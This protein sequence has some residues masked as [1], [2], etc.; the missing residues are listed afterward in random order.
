MT[1]PRD[2][3]VE[4]ARSIYSRGLTHGSTGNL[5]VRSGDRIFITPT[6]SSLGTVQ[7]DEIAEIDLDGTAITQCKPSKEAFIHAAILRIRP[8]LRAVVHTH[9]TYAT[10]VSCLP[11]LHPDSTLPPLTV[12]FEMRV[13]SLPLVPRFRPGD[14]TMTATIEKLAATNAAMLLQNHGPVAAGTTLQ[15]ALDTIEEI[16]HTAHIFLLTQAHSGRTTATIKDNR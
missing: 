5:S 16:E 9:S 3:I 10:A 6:G 2:Q 8:E 7:P 12:Y 13:G 11:G 4:T 14:T 1:H 15:S